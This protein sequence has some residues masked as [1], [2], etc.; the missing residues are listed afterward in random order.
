M[1]D[2]LA[3]YR[4]KRDFGNTPEPDPAAPIARN[5]D[6]FVIHR[7][8]ARSL[9]YDL[10]L[11]HE[12]VLKSWAVPR[13]FS[14]ATAEK[15]LAV[16]TEDH[17][18]EYE[19]FHGRIPKGQYGAGT[20]T[21]WDRGTYEL[22]KI[23]TWEEALQKGE[24]KIILHGKR[25]RGEWHLVR[26]KQ[27][28]NSWLLFKSK[29]RFSG[30]DRDSMLGID[31]DQAMLGD[32]ALPIEPMTHR[33][34]RGSY[35]DPSWLFEMEFAGRRTLAQK[36]FNEVTLVGL[37]TVPPRI[38]KGL[39]SMRADVALLD[40]ILVVVNEHGR[41]DKQALDDALTN[42]AHDKITFYAFDLLQWED[43]DLRALPLV[44]RKA[45]LRAVLTELP[46]VLF[47]DHVTGDGPALMNVI[48][49]AGLPA[50]IAKR[51]ASS[52]VSEASDEWVR[53]PVG[54]EEEVAEPTSPQAIT[55]KKSRFQPT[56]LGKVYWPAE[57]FTK[58]DLLA[59]YHAVADVILPHLQNRPVH[60]NR[61]PD[62]IDGKS[63]YQREVKEGTPDWVGSVDVPHD[64]E[65]VQ[66]HVINDRDS[67]LY[68]ANLGSI[69]LH[70]W[71]SSVGSLYEPDYAVL[72]L[73]PKEAPW[74]DVIRIA[75]AAGKLLRGI[76]LRP[77]LK[78]SGKTGIHIFVPLQRG[79][80]YDHSKM[81]L[82]AVARVLVREL[83]DIATVERLPQNREGKVYLD[84]LQNRKS[85]TIVPPYS[86]R[87]VRGGCVSAPLLWDEL[88]DGDLQPQR[89]TLQTMPARVAERGDLFAKALT[90]K[91]DLMPAIAA[92]E[93]VLKNG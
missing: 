59:Y 61:F 49:D 89:F 14:Y 25:L 44:D 33:A 48:A 21:I 93:D 50:S 42:G 46:G 70:P 55:I 4:K 66:H 57:G 69:D 90:D 40:G 73:D 86:A 92:L 16:R 43:Y 3:D 54:K 24:L 5:D 2:L 78:T 31:L 19:H 56:N 74:R 83:S 39:A 8:E 6:V 81:F 51:A 71:L 7:H 62:G 45:G 91:Q 68:A 35:R 29:D 34:E 63:F 20:M 88:E 72:D 28:K 82:E 67:L 75:R 13:G 85:Q 80:T 15:R 87:P 23:P 38:A 17:P 9:H 1:R 37:D 52:Y 76:R 32:I 18:L 64:D 22:V 79:Y 26:T 12:G 36:A 27:A 58:G 84:F 53:I 47:V 41:P 77:L 60:F 65:I 10:R 11:E 30:P